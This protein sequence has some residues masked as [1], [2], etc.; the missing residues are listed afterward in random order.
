MAE[1]LEPD[2]TPVLIDDVEVISPGLT[3]MVEVHYP[4]AARAR[5]PEAVDDTLRSALDRS[6]LIHQ[7][8]VEISEHAEDPVTAGFGRPTCQSRGTGAHHHGARA[9]HRPGTGLAGQ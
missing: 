8:T 3:G 6:G 9:R 4:G 2:G 5:G 7:V 1:F